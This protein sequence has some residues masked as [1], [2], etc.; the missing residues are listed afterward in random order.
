MPTLRPHRRRLPGTSLNRIVVL[1]ILFGVV[2][3]VILFGKLF[4]L[5]VIRHDE[6]NKKA[7]T[8]QTR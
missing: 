7:L 1:A 2:T 5:Q 6:L 8:Q 4:Q 3:F